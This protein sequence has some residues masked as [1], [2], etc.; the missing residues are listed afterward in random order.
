MA[1]NWASLCGQCGH[2][3]SNHLRLGAEIDAFGCAHCACR[4][5]VDV[6]GDVSLSQAQ[7]EAYV[8]RPDTPRNIW[9]PT[10]TEA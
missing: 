3:V 10:E 4:R 9:D 5:G 8:S 7:F 2:L 6:D 1:K